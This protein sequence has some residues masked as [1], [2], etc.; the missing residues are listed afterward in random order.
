MTRKEFHTAFDIQLD[1]SA[2]ISHPSFLS[3][4]KD[5]WIN[6]A[7]R[8]LI[9]TKYSGNNPLRKGFQQNQKR[10]DDLRTV[11][12]VAT[13]FEDQMVHDI[14]NINGINNYTIEYPNDYWFTVGESTYIYSN[15][16]T[17]PKEGNTPIVKVVD[18]VECTVDNITNKINNKLSEYRLR[19]NY[20]RP[21]R[22]QYDNCI[23]LYTDNEYSILQYELAYVAKPEVFSRTSDNADEE[24]TGMPEHTHDEIVA[25][26]V[27]LAL[28]SIIDDRY[29]IYKAENEI[30]E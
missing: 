20:A 12:K 2:P 10:S 15:N 9:K 30:I 8:N 27:R 1:K 16:A 22:L 28:A 18:V 17:W 4:E 19:H 25:Y 5:Y 24:Y 7:I 23:I 26:A 11:V 14:D 13:Y 3:V 29:P 6:T 21:L